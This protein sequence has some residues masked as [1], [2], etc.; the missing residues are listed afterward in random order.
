MR[1]PLQAAI[2]NNIPGAARDTDARGGVGEGG[3]RGD[4]VDFGGIWKVNS[5]T[6]DV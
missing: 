2:E 1:N 6:F 5:H 3:G 4:G